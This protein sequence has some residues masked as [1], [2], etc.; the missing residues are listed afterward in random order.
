MTI[1]KL[2]T[3]RDVCEKVVLWWAGTEKRVWKGGTGMSL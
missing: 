1:T 3:I 2:E